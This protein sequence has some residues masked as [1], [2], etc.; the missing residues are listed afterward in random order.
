MPELADA[1]TKALA[2]VEAERGRKPCGCQDAA[3]AAGDPFARSVAGGD[4]TTQLNAALEALSG[5]AEP[6]LLSPVDE[7]LESELAFADLSEPLSLTLEEMLEVLERNPG[8]KITLS[9]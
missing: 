5:G 6:D 1:L 9:Y 3:S 2:E 4:L 7:D 8:L